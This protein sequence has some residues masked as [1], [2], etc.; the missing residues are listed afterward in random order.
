MY[1]SEVE[2]GKMMENRFDSTYDEIV[3]ILHLLKSDCMKFEPLF[4]DCDLTQI[5]RSKS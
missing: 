1:I 5:W 2:I 4:E 3:T